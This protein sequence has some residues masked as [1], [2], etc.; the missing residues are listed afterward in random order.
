MIEQ[1][2]GLGWEIVTSKCGG[3]MAAMREAEIHV[4]FTRKGVL[5]RRAV[6]N[7]LRPLL[8]LHGFL[9][10]KAGVEDSVSDRFIRRIGFSPTWAD[11]KYRYYVMTTLPFSK[12]H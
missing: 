11:G 3:C 10:T 9:V 5:T 6:R 7:F 12:E 8:A 4:E 2:A 1:A